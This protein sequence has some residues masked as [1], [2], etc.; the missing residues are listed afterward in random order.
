MEG[1]RAERR[2]KG[3]PLTW[4]RTR[5]SQ[6]TTGYALPLHHE[7]FTSPVRVSIPLRSADNGP[8]QPTSDLKEFFGGSCDIVRYRAVSCEI[9]RYRA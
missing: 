3:N 5:I 6:A 1:L 9:V 4:S 8:C 2:T 7:R